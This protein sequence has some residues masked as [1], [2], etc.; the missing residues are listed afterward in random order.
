MKK[1]L[2]IL[3]ALVGVTHALNS[4]A[5]FSKSLSAVDSAITMAAGGYNSV[6]FQLTGT[7]S[8]TVKFEGT[9]NGTTWTTVYAVNQNGGAVD[10][11]A[12]ANGVYLLSG[13]G[14][15]NIRARCS[16][17]VSGTI[18]IQAM[19][20]EGTGVVSLLNQSSAGASSNVSVTASVL[21]TL[22]A[23]S[24]KQSDGTQK[25]QVVDGSGNV[26]GA[27]SNALDVNIK[28][29]A[30]S[31]TQYDDDAVYAGDGA[32]VT[33]A[34]VVRRDAN[35]T[36]A[37]ADG[38]VAPLQVNAAGAL[39]VDASGAAVPI[40]DNS[41]SLTVD[42]ATTG[43]GTATGALRVELPTNGTGVIATVGAVT[44]I[45]NALPA[46][47]NAIGKLAANSGVDIGDVDVTS[48]PNVTLAAGTNTNE[49]VGDAAH[50]AAVAG[51][52]VLQGIEARTSNGTAVA[53]GD[54]TRVQGTI[55]GKLV[56]KPHSVYGATWT[57][58]AA[59]GGITNTTAA[60]MKTAAAAGVRN[61]VTGIQV[62]NGHATVS[63][64]VLV[65]DGAAGTVVHRGWA[66]AAGGG[67]AATFDVP[68]CGTAA[69]LME[70]VPVTTG[71]AIYVNAQGYTSAE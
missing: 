53:N 4:T 12:T 63:T 38:D 32:K 3:F 36:L 26:I 47:T 57:Y 45:T 66:Q 16:A 39:K 50:D 41:G 17:R 10:S 60:T 30:S 34:G 20:N 25:T 23:T 18:V 2:V 22:A 48:L 52:P 6:S 44:A 31:G 58:A 46:G 43:S 49:V 11:V 64:E 55:E 5:S 37:G 67:Y 15:K 27:T 40:T 56:T 68:I 71:S 19:G 8:A 7:Y 61:C 65:R 9:V 70:V 51:N 14:F 24:T 1:L 59:S 35:T 29:G 62:I 28:S 42:Y 54:V 33:M 21:P 69:T 13:N